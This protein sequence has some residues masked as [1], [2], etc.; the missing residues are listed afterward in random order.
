VDVASAAGRHYAR[1]QIGRG[2]GLR[3]LAG[4]EVDDVDRDSLS[5]PDA[6]ILD[7]TMRRAS[8]T[9][10]LMVPTACA[11]SPRFRRT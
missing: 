1:A 11:A 6:S 7:A 3:H 5:I 4:D 8:D 2:L 9:R 10:H